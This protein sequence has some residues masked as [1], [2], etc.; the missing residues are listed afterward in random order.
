M[1]IAQCAGSQANVPIMTSI[2]EGNSLADVYD[3]IY[4]G[5]VEFGEVHMGQIEKKTQANEGRG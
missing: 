2:Y 1:D 3:C 5:E 4:K